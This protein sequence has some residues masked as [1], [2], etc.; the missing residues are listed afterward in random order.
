[1]SFEVFISYP[2]EDKAAADEACAAL[3]RAGI[4]CWIA[5]RDVAPGTAWAASIIE[6]LDRCRVMVLI[7]SSHANDSQQIHREVQR[8]FDR[9]IPVVPLRI[10]NVEPTQSLAY[11]LGSVHW[12][13][14][15]TPPLAAH[16]ERLGV[17]VRTF[18]DRKES[19]V[20]TQSQTPASRGDEAWPAAPRPTAAPG[21]RNS[22][23]L[24]GA[25]AA[26]SALT[27]AA[28]AWLFIQPRAPGTTTTTRPP[29]AIA[30]TFGGTMQCDKLP[31][32][33]T[34]LHTAVT[35]I[36]K[37]GNATFH[38]DVYSGDAKRKIGIETGTGKLAAD[39]IL[40]LK[41][42]W[43]ST[44]ARFDGSYVGRMSASGGTLSGKQTL[45]IAGARHERNCTITFQKKSSDG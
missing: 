21:R 45:L 23:W 19:L 10:E 2:H 1:M 25:A 36:L 35:L 12:L 20:R 44:N 31:W 22:P 4:G 8:A 33:A 34:M 16:F 13:D 18:L 24:V 7:F 5:P 26:A 15:F 9:A 11:F 43:V 42:S 41:T 40:E 28:A 32:T 27:A 38:R 14:A 39:G 29:A 3:E 37:D 30:G 17:A 6:A